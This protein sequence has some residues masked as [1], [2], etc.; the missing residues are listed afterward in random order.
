LGKCWQKSIS[1]VNA[2]I[3]SPVQNGP[4]IRPISPT[5]FSGMVPQTPQGDRFMKVEKRKFDSVLEKLLKSKPEPRKQIKIE[6]RK[7]SNA[8]ILAKP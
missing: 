4:D 8:P 6:G 3:A 5:T 7:G 1:L 2:T